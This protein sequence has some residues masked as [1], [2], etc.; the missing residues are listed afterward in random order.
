[1]LFGA[2]RFYEGIIQVPNP[3]EPI[4]ISPIKMEDE[5]E[6]DLCLFRD[7]FIPEQCTTTCKYDQTEWLVD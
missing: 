7:P 4:M 2:N 3:C 1:M 5:T 6:K